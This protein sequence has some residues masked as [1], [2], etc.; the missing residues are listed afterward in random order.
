MQTGMMHHVKGCLSA[1]RAAE[2]KQQAAEV[3]NNG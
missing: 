1:F 2:F 3:E